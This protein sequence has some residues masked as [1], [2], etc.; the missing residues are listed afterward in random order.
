MRKLV[1]CITLSLWQSQALAAGFV[2]SDILERRLPTVEFDVD[3]LN[4]SLDQLE[5]LNAK[6][7]VLEYLTKGTIGRATYLEDLHDVQQLKF[8]IENNLADKSLKDIQAL[9]IDL[10]I[11]YARIKLPEARV[12]DLRSRKELSKQERSELAALEK[13]R[14]SSL[15]VIGKKFSKY[16]ALWNQ[17]ESYKTLRRDDRLRERAEVVQRLLGV[18]DSWL[19][20]NPGLLQYA[21]QFSVNGGDAESFLRPSIEQL[22]ELMLGRDR[23]LSQDERFVGLFTKLNYDI[24]EQLLENLKQRGT[25]ILSDQALYGY[26]Q[27]ILGSILRGRASA[28]QT[29][30]ITEQLRRSLDDVKAI[31]NHYKGI[32]HLA[33]SNDAIK[34]KFD[35][36]ME[37]N[38]M[39]KS[40]KDG[41]PLFMFTFARRA[42][43]EAIRA[44]KELKS[45]AET[46]MSDYKIKSDLTIAQAMT[47][48]EEARELGFLPSVFNPRAQGAF[49]VAH[50]LWIAGAAAL[51]GY[52]VGIPGLGTV[53]DELLEK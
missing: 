45:Y 31:V 24:K 26:L 43:D 28:E 32:D 49:A 38:A 29:K 22:R 11:A 34:T 53:A 13:I 39:F 51:L 44:W 20:Q 41:I 4:G 23:N 1:I 36:F 48:A 21:K 37:M 50:S 5:R 52:Y 3:Q 42:D 27:S 46:H 2:C 10:A 9:S 15:Q 6:Q 7:K 19:K 14:R 17:L 18:T 8:N 47:K 35:F 12:L 25:S 40:S 30:V 16:R 33:N